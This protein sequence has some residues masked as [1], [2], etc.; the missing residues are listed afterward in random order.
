[1]RKKDSKVQELSGLPALNF[2]KKRDLFLIILQIEIQI[3]NNHN[4][5]S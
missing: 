5:A 2:R 1:M 4:S 3:D